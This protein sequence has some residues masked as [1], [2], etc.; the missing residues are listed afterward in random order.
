MTRGNKQGDQA[1]VDEHV[2]RCV[3]DTAEGIKYAGFRCETN[4]CENATKITGEGHT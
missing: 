2:D 4:A 1:Q 3:A